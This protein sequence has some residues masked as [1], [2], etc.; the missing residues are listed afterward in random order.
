MSGGVWG[1]ENVYRESAAEL[2]IV[3]KKNRE[4]IFRCKLS[5]SNSG[6]KAQGIVKA[7]LSL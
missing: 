5:R 4:N 6:S 2:Q 1:W 7:K 3:Y